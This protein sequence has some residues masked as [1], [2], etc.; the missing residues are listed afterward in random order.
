MLNNLLKLKLGL[1]LLNFQ[2][3][4]MYTNNYWYNNK[5]P[6]NVVHKGDYNAGLL[7]YM[8]YLLR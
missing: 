2:T 3:I 6:Q 1:L 5:N 8:H 4:L 7:P